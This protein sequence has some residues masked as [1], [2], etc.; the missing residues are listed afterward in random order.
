MSNRR[1]RAPVPG[2]PARIAAFP[3]A[4][5]VDFRENPSFDCQFGIVKPDERGYRPIYTS[6]SL[7][8]MDELTAEEFKTRKPT[9]A[10]RKAAEF[11]SMF[12]WGV[13]GANP[14]NYTEDGVL[15]PRKN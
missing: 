13:P 6:L 14:E 9:Q 1:Q 2:S 10:E 15:L 8:E 11:G 7:D 3:K 4:V 5:V 12:G